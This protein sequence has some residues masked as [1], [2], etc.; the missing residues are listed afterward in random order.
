[1]R[2]VVRRSPIFEKI[3]DSEENPLLQDQL[4]EEILDYDIIAQL[5]LGK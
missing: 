5:I 1:F 3:F 2:A 4:P